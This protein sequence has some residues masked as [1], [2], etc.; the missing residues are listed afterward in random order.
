MSKTHLSADK[1]ETCYHISKTSHNWLINN[2]SPRKRGE[3][4]DTLITQHRLNEKQVAQRLTAI[5]TQLA[6][7]LSFF[8]GAG[9]E[10]E[11][12]YT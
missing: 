1:V 7:L 12:I 8:E 5:E 9:V 2:V 3:L 10:A 11:T 6:R 4:I